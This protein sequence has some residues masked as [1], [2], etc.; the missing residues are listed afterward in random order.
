MITCHCACGADVFQL[1]IKRD[2]QV[3]LLTCIAGHHSLL[4]DSRD[5]WADALQDGRPKLSRCRCGSTTF[6]VDLQYEFRDTGEVRH[7]QI[8][9]HCSLCGR[10]QQPVNLDVKYSP[11][12]DLVS[13]PIDPI[14]QPWLQPKRRT[15]TSFWKPADG[16]RF[17][18]YVV[19]SLGARVFAET[20]PYEF[21]EV[22]FADITIPS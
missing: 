7:I 17:A 12:D 2:E 18:D 16:E 21:S 13:R 15:I 4:L 8:E 1:R 22:Q 3:G 11:T 6:R 14:E 9:P 19:G 10:G 5:Y 20:K